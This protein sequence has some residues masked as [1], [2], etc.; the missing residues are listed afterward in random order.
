MLFRS[1]NFDSLK[2]HNFFEPGSTYG[3]FNY[4]L[5]FEEGDKRP[6]SIRLPTPFLFKVSRN[7]W[8]FSEE[9]LDAYLTSEIPGH[10]DYQELDEEESE[11]HAH[12][13][14]RGSHPRTTMGKD[15]RRSRLLWMGYR[16]SRRHGTCISPSISSMSTRSSSRN[17]L[18]SGTHGTTTTVRPKS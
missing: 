11:G 3:D 6:R 8:S 10:P 14:M 9:V 15:L 18:Q 7:G 1:L 5:L 2:L 4:R 16:C 17:H 12:L 13:Y